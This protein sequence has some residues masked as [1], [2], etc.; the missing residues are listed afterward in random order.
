MISLT[1]AQRRLNARIAL[2]ASKSESNRALIIKGLSK[3]PIELLNLASARDTQ[4]M[5]RLMESEGHVLDV[6]DAGTTM[7]FLTAFMAAQ[8]RDQILTGTPR[9]CKRPIG[10]LVDALRSLGAEIQY[11]KQEGY[12]PLHIVSK[13]TQME[14]GE[15]EIAGNVSSQFIS[16]IL[17]ISPTLKQGVKLHLTGDISSR[18]YIDMTRGLMSHFGVESHWEGATIVVPEQSYQGGT[19]TIESDWSAAS[20]WYSMLSIATEGEVFL[21][22]LKSNSWQGDRGISDIMVHFGIQTQFEEGG[23][24]LTKIPM[25][26]PQGLLEWDFTK[27]PDLA[28]TM[29]VVSAATGK[30]IKMSGLHTLRVKETDRIE[31][32]KEQLAKFQVDFLVEGDTATVRKQAIFTEALIETYDDHRMAMAFSPLVYKFGKLQLDDP[33]VVQKSYPEFWQHLASA[34]VATQEW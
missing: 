21:E 9:M 18:P 25:E 32:L 2:P 17:M 31:A 26:D 7:R 34:G 8:G 23:I 11:W 6:I 12:P 4:T 13:G 3:E 27:T 22:G 1:A 29:A 28:Q 30:P 16:A 10:I 15:I 20:Y 5:I 33:E 24:R 19:L 14:G